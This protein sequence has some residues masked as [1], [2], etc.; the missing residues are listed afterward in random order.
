MT[1]PASAAPASAPPP[2]PDGLKTLTERLNRWE[3]DGT[4]DRVLSLV[5]GLVGVA[6]A[7]SE[8]MVASAGAGLINALSLL[9]AI[10]R[11]ERTREGLLYLV[12][13]LG[14]WKETGALETLVTLA[15]GAVGL[16]QAT[17]DSMVAEAGTSFIGAMRFVQGL[18]PWHEVEPLLESFRDNAPSVQALL[19]SV[20]ILKD[21]AALDR[22]TAAIPPITGIFGLGRAFRDP[23]IQRGL[24]VALVLMKRLGRAG[25]AGA[26]PS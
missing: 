18:P 23:E 26:P 11:D 15:E 10:A 16:S 20:E 19:G 6:D 24:H 8:Q 13:R 7:T 4:L 14:E 12:D 3:A 1:V 25:V 9:D 2:T 5:E 22:E 21:R 17:T